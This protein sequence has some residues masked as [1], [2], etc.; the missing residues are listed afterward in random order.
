[1]CGIFGW[2]GDPPDDKNQLSN[3]LGTVL[4]HRGPD[5]GGFD[6]GPDWGLGF[7]RL[8]ILDLSPLGHQPMCSQGGRYWLAFNGEIYNYLELRKKLEQQGERFISTSDTEVLLR[9]LQVYGASGLKMLNGMFALAFIDTQEKTFILARDRL[10]QKPIYY[11]NQPGQLRFASELKALL[12][13]PNAP[14]TLNRTALVEY[15]SLTYISGDSCIFEDYK[16]L[17]PAHYMQGSLL[18]PNDAVISSYWDLEIN[19]DAGHSEISAQQLGELDELLQHAIKIRLRSD[20][21]VGIFLSGGLD[22]GLIATLASQTAAGS[23]PLALTVGFEGSDFDES[24]LAKEIAAHAGLPH[25][26]IFQ[27]PAQLAD[28]DSISRAFD[29]PFGDSSS[30]PTLAICQAARKRGI[31]FLSG[32]GGDEALGGYRRYIKAQKYQWVKHLPK[33]A[34]TGLNHVS[35]FLPLFSSL[36]YQIK[37]T[38][39][40]DMG[41]AAAFDETPADPILYQILSKEDRHLVEQGSQPLWARWAQTAQNKS[42]LMRQQTL[43]YSLYLPDDILVKMDR[44]SM[45]HSIEVRSPFLDHRLVEWCAKL[46]RNALMNGHQGKLP[47]RLLGEKYLP[48]EAVT[49]KKRGFG[50]PV[51][52]WFNSAEGQALLKE[53][54]LSKEAIERNL[55]DPKTVSSLIENQARSG[56]GRNLGSWLWRLLVLDSWGR[57]YLEDSIPDLEPISF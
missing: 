14:R 36:R 18:Y 37:K 8:S 24:P 56:N 10:G 40:Q 47:L 53:R 51:S 38:A 43:D 33:S 32:D 35:E 48:K 42:L 2:L 49:A 6:F 23:K 5:D 1:M 19:D 7:R 13:W 3:R 11:L 29:E 30:L 34:T 31:V 25:E 16:K 4:Q 54:L 55:W 20:V 39:V 22:S 21:P 46:P 50:S 17:P 44:A 12:A 26:T 15:Y 9:I 41:Y 52:E 57:K 27:K 28:L 45:A